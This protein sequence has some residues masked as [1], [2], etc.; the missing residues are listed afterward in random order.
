MVKSVLNVG[1]N[2]I[3]PYTDTGAVGGQAIDLG[4]SVG[5]EWFVRWML[6]NKGSGLMD[7]SAAHALGKPFEGGLT[8]YFPGSSLAKGE[9]VDQLM[10]GFKNSL[11]IFIG[12]WLWDVANKGFAFNFPSFWEFF[13]IAGS[14]TAQRPLLSLARGYLPSAVQTQLD[15]ADAIRVS[16]ENNSNLKAAAKSGFGAD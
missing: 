3:A 12:A 8:A 7:I 2:L 9:T 10:T 13:I 5:I 11:P 4:S 14:K 6:K 16:A 15:K 1:K